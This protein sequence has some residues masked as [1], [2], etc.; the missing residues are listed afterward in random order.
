MRRVILFFLGFLAVSGYATEY[1]TCFFNGQLGNQMFQVAAA[2]A[3][4][5]DHG[6]EAIF[7]KVCEARDAE[8]NARYIFHRLNRTS[9]PEGEVFY[10]YEDPLHPNVY[11]PIP[12]E[13]GENLC[14]VGHFESEKY[15]AKHSSVIRELFAPSQEILDA[16]NEKYG[17]L[18]QEQTVAIHV[19]TFLPDGRDP[20]IKGLGGASWS[21]FTAAMNLFPRDAHFLVFSD[22][23][24]WVKKRF[25][26]T[27]RNVTFIEGNPHHIDFYLMSLCKHQIVSPESTFSWWAAWLNN[28]PHKKIVIADTW[29]D[30]TDNDTIP[31]G[32]I[33][34]RKKPPH[35]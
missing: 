24:E 21:Y 18:L 5:L 13:P 22:S 29:N 4:A 14:L 2:V 30:L 20:R 10:L 9:L 27:Y 1:V 11:T 25:P 7:P 6:S 34:L 8:I 33:K 32:W 35:R 23:I 15:F 16:M 31:E 19:R 28:N 12:Y 3:Y 26:P 17:A